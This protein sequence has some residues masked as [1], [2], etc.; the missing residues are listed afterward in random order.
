MRDAASI[1][2]TTEQAYIRVISFGICDLHWKARFDQ[3][4]HKYVSQIYM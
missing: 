3:N 4:I 1:P 2:L